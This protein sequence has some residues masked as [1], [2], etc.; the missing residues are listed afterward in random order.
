MPHAKRTNEIFWNSLGPNMPAFF[1]LYGQTLPGWSSLPNAQCGG[2]YQSGGTAPSVFTGQIYPIL[3][4]NCTGC[5]SAVGNANF[6]VGNIANTYSDLL[7]VFAKNGSSHYIV[8]S[9]PANS[10]LYERITTGGVGQ[11]MPLGGANLVVDDTDSPGDGV[12]DASEINS[13]INS[14]AP[15]P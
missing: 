6:A 15:G 13:W 10:L 1:E 9:N 11:R 12:A 14:G 7:T 5:H 3:F 4:N 2:F 8:P